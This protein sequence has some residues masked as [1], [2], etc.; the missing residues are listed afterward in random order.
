[1]D[2]DWPEIPDTPDQRALIEEH[3]AKMR[4][5]YPDLVPFLEDIAPRE[6]SDG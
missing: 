5:K 1:M 4:R 3:N 6:S 2:H